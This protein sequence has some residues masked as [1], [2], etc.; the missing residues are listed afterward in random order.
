MNAD[1]MIR[2]SLL[3]QACG[4]IANALKSIDERALR[5]IIAMRERVQKDLKPD[6]RTSEAAIRGG[7]AVTEELKVLLFCRTELVTRQ[8]A[9]DDMKA[10]VAKGEECAARVGV[11]I[12][13]TEQEDR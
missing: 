3:I 7:L 11:V 4:S 2:M 5:E 6:A 10:A 1:E 9:F 8:A 13:G 12:A